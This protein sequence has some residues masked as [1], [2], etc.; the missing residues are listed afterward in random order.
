MIEDSIIKGKF[1]VKNQ[2]YKTDNLM[3]VKIHKKS[4]KK[5]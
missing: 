4:W 1:L 5:R 2:I 3:W